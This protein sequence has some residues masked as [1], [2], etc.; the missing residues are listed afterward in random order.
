MLILLIIAIKNSAKSISTPISIKIKIKIKIN[1]F[2]GDWRRMSL[3]EPEDL[4]GDI[5]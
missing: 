1:R 5:L 2:R 4:V 3:G